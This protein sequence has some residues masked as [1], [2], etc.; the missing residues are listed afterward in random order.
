ME[1]TLPALVRVCSQRIPVLL[2]L[3][4]KSLLFR[5]QPEQEKQQVDGRDSHG[6]GGRSV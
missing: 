1:L 2:R 6:Q 3:A 4:V 5:V